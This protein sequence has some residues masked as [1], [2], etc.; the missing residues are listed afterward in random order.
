MALAKASLE[1]AWA[2]LARAKHHIA[3][4]KVRCDAY[5]GSH[6]YFLLEEHDAHTGEQVVK[7]RLTKAIPVE[8]KSIAADA[9]SNLRSALDQA[10]YAV[11]VAA[12]GRGKNTYFPFHDD[13]SG[14]LGA[15]RGGSAEI[16]QE[17]FSLIASF[18]PYK[19]GNDLLWSLN[20]LSNTNKHRLISP[21]V[22]N[23]LGSTV[24][25]EG[26]RGRAWIPQHNWR[27]GKN[28]L[29]LARHSPDSDVRYNFNIFVC[30]TF[31]DPEPVSSQPVETVL[32][33]LASEVESI[34][35]AI[36]AESGRIGLFN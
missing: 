17:I 6:P 16:P 1:E 18:K 13:A 29:E 28:D 8:L 22:L 12:G 26:S 35:M 4:L 10:G 19:G 34:L 31:S 9:V 11:S 24:R 30:V 5:T 2:T 3:D 32:N 27:R 21:T 20:K 14:I 23:T 36:E 7:M 33:A 25:V 15:K